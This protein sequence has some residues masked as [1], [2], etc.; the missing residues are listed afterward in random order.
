MTT[1]RSTLRFTLALA[2]ALVLGGCAVRTEIA[3]SP[4]TKEWRYSSGKNITFAHIKT[5][6]GAE[7]L[8]LTSDASSV[9]SARGTAA[10]GI[11]DTSG[12]FIPVNALTGVGP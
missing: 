11:I 3:Y 12:R 6:D 10:A 2:A 9:V 1:S 7:Q 8:V 5:A 4:E